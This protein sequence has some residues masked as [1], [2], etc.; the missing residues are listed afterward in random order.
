[1]LAQAEAKLGLD[2]GGG[3]DQDEDQKPAVRA[4]DQR[5]RR[6]HKLEQENAALRAEAAGLRERLRGC[7]TSRS[8]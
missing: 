1:M 2:R 4:P 6:I 7:A 8:T 5:D 3:D